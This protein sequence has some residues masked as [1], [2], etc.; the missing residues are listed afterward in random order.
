[1]LWLHDNLDDNIL[2]PSPSYLY[3][4]V[5]P[6][7][8]GTYNA[9]TAT[10]AEV[11]LSQTFQ[12]AIANFAKDPVDSPAPNWPAY[13]P[14]FLGIA[15]NPTLAK[16]SYDG[17]VD[18]NDFIQSVQPISTV[19]TCAKFTCLLP[20]YRILRSGWTVHRMGSFPGRTEL[21]GQCRGLLA[22]NEYGGE[23]SPSR[24]GIRISLVC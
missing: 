13:E 21:L 20:N 10:S 15:H 3:H 22:Y 6:I 14:G 11:E 24:P 18:P 17:N 4:F 16:I 2:Q 9:S 7:L 8:F 1:M 23:P 12:T 5:V 19:S